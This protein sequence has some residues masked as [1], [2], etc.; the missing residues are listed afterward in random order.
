MLLESKL[1]VWAMV[2]GAFSAAM[3]VC[4]VVFMTSFG[5]VFG[6]LFQY[7]I[8]RFGLLFLGAMFA[9]QVFA[10]I[11]SKKLIIRTL[12]A[13]LMLMVSSFLFVFTLIKIEEW[14]SLYKAQAAVQGFCDSRKHPDTDELLVLVGADKKA[15]A[16]IECE[17][18]EG[19]LVFSRYVY[20]TEYWRYSHDQHRFLLTE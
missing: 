10:V 20:G 19:P 4:S 13:V 3:V 11:A 5:E 7:P 9:I 2:A 15:V 14:L 1:K 12:A 6:E 18:D 17:G 8:Y 16:G